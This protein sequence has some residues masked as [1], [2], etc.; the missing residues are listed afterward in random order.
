MLNITLIKFILKTGCVTLLLVGGI[1]MLALS[2][3]K[4]TAIASNLFN[5][6]D[7]E[8]T[9]GNVVFLKVMG[10]IMTL[11]GLFLIW[12]FFIYLPPMPKA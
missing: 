8:I 9:T 12:K 4:C 7:L 3:E 6:R 1:Y 10:T 11:L 2:R 5:V